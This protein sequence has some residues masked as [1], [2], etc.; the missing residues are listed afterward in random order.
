MRQIYDITQTTDRNTPVIEG[1]APLSVTL[2]D[3]IAGGA[4]ANVSALR[5]SPHIG[6]HMDAPRHLFDGAPDV[7][8]LPLSVCA[9]RCLV[10]DLSEAPA[11][12]PVTS[13]ELSAVP[14]GEVRVILKTRKR[15]MSRTEEPFRPVTPEAIDFLLRRGVKLLGLDTL[16]VDPLTSHSLDAHRLALAAGMVLLENLC[17]ENICEGIFELFALPL[18]IEGLEASPVRAILMEFENPTGTVT[19]P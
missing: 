1:D 9:G 10:L 2:T 19:E 4:A 14:P 3:S 17:L 11:D 12:A 16:G 13:E 7:L 8:G 5:M 6:T 15:P 18:K